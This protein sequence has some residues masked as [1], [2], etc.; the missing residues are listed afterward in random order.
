MS[1]WRHKIYGVPMYS[2]ICKLKNLKP[3]FKSLRRCKGDLGVNVHEASQELLAL[4]PTF[5]PLLMLEKV[6]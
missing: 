2:V 4:H 1:L 5:E 6:V 3:V